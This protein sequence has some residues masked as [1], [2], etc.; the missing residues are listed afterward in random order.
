MRLVAELRSTVLLEMKDTNEG[1]AM[2][3]AFEQMHPRPVG[4][5]N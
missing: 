2:L 1:S 5:I 4:M 3:Y